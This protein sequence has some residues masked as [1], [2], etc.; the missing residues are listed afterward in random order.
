MVKSL[1]FVDRIVQQ[2]YIYEFIKPYIYKRFIDDTCAC[3]DKKGTHYAVN[4]VEKYMRL[5]KRKYNKYYILKCDVKKFFYSID[6]EI[7]FKI[8]QDIISDKKILNLTYQL[9]YDG[10]EKGIPIGNY[11]SQYFA[12]IYLNVLDYYAKQELKVKY[13]VRYM[14]YF[15][16]LVNSKETAKEL[17]KNI[18]EFLLKRLNLNLNTKSR[19]YPNK[20]G[21]NFCGYRIYET[22]RLLRK[23]AKEN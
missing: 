3:I 17:K 21:V 22:H 12:N 14:D 6:K 10:D 16:I 2:W 20:M 9:I 13:Y 4:K 18:E 15:I 7:L 23:R 8:M 1:P 5:M 19:Y 11:T